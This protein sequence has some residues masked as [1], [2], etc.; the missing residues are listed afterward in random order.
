MDHYSRAKLRKLLDYSLFIGN[1]EDEE[2]QLHVAQSASH[3]MEYGFLVDVLSFVCG[4]KFL[5]INERA[6]RLVKRAQRRVDTVLVKFDVLHYLP[7]MLL[8]ILYSKRSF[9]FCDTSVCCLRPDQSELHV[10]V[11]HVSLDRV[12]VVVRDISSRYKLQV[13]DIPYRAKKTRLRV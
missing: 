6:A 8:G 1:A 11:A 9:G 13:S 4:Q 5:D 3:D 2:H 10:Q 12:E 7:Q